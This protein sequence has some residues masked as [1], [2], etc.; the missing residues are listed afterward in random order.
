MRLSLLEKETSPDDFTQHTSQEPR[1]HEL[2]AVCLKNIST[3]LDTVQ[4]DC[5]GVAQEK[6]SNDR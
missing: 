4:H 2:V 1:F 6:E 5:L 3:G